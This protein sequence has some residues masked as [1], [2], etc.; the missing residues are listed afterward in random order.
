[1]RAA[2]QRSGRVFYYYD[3]GGKP[4]KWIPLGGDYVL[5]V[6]QWAKLN[7]SDSPVRPT[8]G[9]A[10]AT[11]K[12]SPA[13]TKLSTGSQSDYGYAL[14]NLL[15]YFGEA[16]LDDVL[17][18]HLTAY[19]ELRCQGT[20]KLK[21]SEHRANREITMLGTV[22]R[23]ARSKNLTKNDP[24]E[25]IKLDKLPGRKNVYIY[26]EMLDAVYAQAS[27]DLKEAIDL[28]YYL[29]QRPVD[30]LDMRVMNQ[31]GGMMEYRQR[32]TGTPQRI[33][34]SGGLDE[35][36]KRIAKRK[37]GFEV[38]CLYLLVDE[39]GKKMTKHK[40]RSR[41]EAARLAAGI[42]GKDFQF[43]DLRRKA[44]SDLRD[45]A[46]IEAA[47]DQLGHRSITQTEHYTGAARGRI[48]NKIPAQRKAK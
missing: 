13:F 5:A 36:L 14:E 20:D 43:R 21:A 22:F 31:R 29:G 17:P 33:A 44:G 39:R 30:L 34:I 24:K 32:K 8:V 4:R 9:Y 37:S 28:A 26:D 10:I 40:L 12:A 15:T 1:M 41:F 47:Q 18:S 27:E 19:H 2:R 6:Q 3:E 46:G 16:P 35:L 42:E 23:Y 11:Y 38:P 7:L 48:I 45:Q 25:S